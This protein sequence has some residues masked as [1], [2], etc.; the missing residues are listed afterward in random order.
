MRL[1]QLDRRILSRE[2]FNPCAITR[3][4]FVENGKIELETVYKSPPAFSPSST[5]TGGGL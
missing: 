2:E 1:F 4:R 5:D 3:G